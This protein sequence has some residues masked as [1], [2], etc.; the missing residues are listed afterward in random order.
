MKTSLI[1]IASD[2]LAGI[3]L[4]RSLA[5]RESCTRE[6]QADYCGG[7]GYFAYAI[8]LRQIPENRGKSFFIWKQCLTQSIVSFPG[9]GSN[10]NSLYFSNRFMQTTETESAPMVILHLSSLKEIVLVRV[11]I[12]LLFSNFATEMI[13][14]II[15]YLQKNGGTNIWPKKRS[16][17]MRGRCCAAGL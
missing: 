10:W 8:N 12:F 17:R 11:A 7:R 9:P 1:N 2:L 3:I 14:E 15:L 13:V 6:N 4:H 16:G 5:I